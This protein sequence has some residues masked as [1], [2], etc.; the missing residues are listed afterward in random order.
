MKLPRL[1]LPVLAALALAGAAPAEAK[2]RS[3]FAN[4]I[5][6]AQ[7]GKKPDR[8]RVTCSTDGFARVNGRDPR[9]GPVACSAVSEVD[10]VTK[11]GNDR[12]NLSGVDGR[13][14]VRDFPGFGTG[15][16]AAGALGPGN[17]R[18]VGSATAFNLV[19]GGGGRDFGKGGASRDSMQGGDDR[20]VLTTLGGNDVLVGQAG[21]DT[22]NGGPGDDLASGSSDDDRLNGGA[23]IDLLAGGLGM[24]QLRGGPGDDELNGGPQKDR[25]DG[26]GGKNR[27][28]QGGK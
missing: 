17:D 25:L 2:I 3:S 24:D 9:S 15:T 18:F 19:L 16:G 20:D 22:L 12:V 10:A 7:G 23:G 14:G 4:G 27:L 11:G 5:L 6:T 1:I 8:I 13:F 26:G 21:P 28:I